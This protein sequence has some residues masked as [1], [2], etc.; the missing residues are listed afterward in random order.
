MDGK[1]LG[2]K[3][4]QGTKG[5]QNDPTGGKA[6]EAVKRQDPKAAVQAQQASSQ[7]AAAAAAVAARNR[8]G[9]EVREI[10][11]DA[12][13][14]NVHSTELL[15]KEAELGETRYKAEVQRV[16]GTAALNL[17]KNEAA[18]RLGH[19]TEHDQSGHLS[20]AS[21]PPGLEF[22]HSGYSSVSSSGLATPAEND[23]PI[24]SSLRPIHD[25]PLKP[26]G[27]TFAAIDA[28]FEHNVASENRSSDHSARD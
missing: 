17:Q 21:T 16:G 13:N 5:K 18:A 15:L 10:T 3:A 9:S 27:N 26:T 6:V 23:H 11:K 24:A 22:D 20:G 14:S 7:S 2:P 4:N 8:P 28:A 25:L 1:A 12:A 19:V